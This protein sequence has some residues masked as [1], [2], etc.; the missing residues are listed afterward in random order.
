[1]TIGE[2][3]MGIR[4][5]YRAATRSRCCQYRAGAAIVNG[6]GEILAT[7]SRSLKSGNNLTLCTGNECLYAR[8]NRRCGTSDP[9]KEA[10]ESALR[11]GMALEG[12]TLFLAELDPR[13]KS[14]MRK[15]SIPKRVACC[16]D[17]GELIVRHKLGVALWQKGSGDTPTLVLYEWRSFRMDPRLH[18][19]NLILPQGELSLVMGK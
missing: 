12:A 16:A 19:M 10:V 3:S 13:E 2:A 18:A 4:E 8:K 9:V 5:A 11:K 14:E 1:M 15:F 6:K 17:C 7:G